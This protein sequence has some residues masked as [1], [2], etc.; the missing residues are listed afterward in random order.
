MAPLHFPPIRPLR[1]GAVVLLLTGC[2]GGLAGWHRTPTP[3]PPCF[4]PRQQVQIWQ[5]DHNAIWHGVELRGDTLLG[6][7][8]FRP[9]ECDSCRQRLPMAAVDSVRLG[10]MEQV[11]WLVAASPWILTGAMLAVLRFNWPTD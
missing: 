4:A 9:L 11:G 7:P 8:Y 1:I 5:R 3:L 2:A 6:I 10:S